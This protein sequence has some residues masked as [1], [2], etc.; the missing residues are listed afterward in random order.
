MRRHADKHM[1]D[2]LQANAEAA[3]AAPLVVRHLHA[4]PAV[5]IEGDATPHDIMRALAAVHERILKLYDACD[6]FL[7]DPTDPTRYSIDPRASEVLV[8][9]TEWSNGRPRPAKATLQELLRKVAGITL[10]T[11]VSIQW[12]AKD[13]RDLVLRTAERLERQLEMVAKLL[14]MLDAPGG[15]MTATP[16]WVR[17]R[18]ALMEA[19][20]P[21]PEARSA[22]V[23]AL[24]EG[25]GGGDAL[26]LG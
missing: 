14:G 10:G 6:R 3:G 1:L 4:L 16:E 20:A 5:S 18:S 9:Y 24:V 26:A 8:I 12:A 13:P 19:L 23:D 15:R 22:V 25:D 17:V 21:Y 11:V 7:Q 2:G